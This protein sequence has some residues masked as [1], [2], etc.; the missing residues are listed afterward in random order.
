M[1]AE[2]VAFLSVFLTLGAAPAFAG[3][4]DSDLH[5]PDDA[6]SVN[7]SQEFGLSS[8]RRSIDSFLGDFEN[9]YAAPET[10]DSYYKGT[11]S[12]TRK[13]RLDALEKQ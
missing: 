13:E 7:I 4:R 10:S 1:K 9:P 8:G 11:A 6:G 12:E 2:A 3:D 5:S